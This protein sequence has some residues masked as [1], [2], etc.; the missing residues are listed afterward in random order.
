MYSFKV[1]IILFRLETEWFSRSIGAKCLSY[2]DVLQLSQVL[3][4]TA[5][6]QSK[7]F[8]YPFSGVTDEFKT[9]IHDIQEAKVLWMLIFMLIFICHFCLLCYGVWYKLATFILAFQLLFRCYLSKRLC[10]PLRQC[11]IL[12]SFYGL[13]L[14]KIKFLGST[15]FARWDSVCFIIAASA[16]IS[17]DPISRFVAE[18]KWP[19]SRASL[20]LYW[21]CQRCCSSWGNDGIRIEKRSPS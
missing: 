11:K 9:F 1:F 12:I 6:G 4:Y 16:K 21:R 7:S 14:H 19:W 18:G 20:I 15:F 3:Y 2:I 5:D 17:C 13:K 10:C 8:F